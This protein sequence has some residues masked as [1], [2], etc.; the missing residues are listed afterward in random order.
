LPQDISRFLRLYQVC[1]GLQLLESETA[2]RQSLRTLAL[3]A[4]HLQH[5]HYTLLQRK[6]SDTR[7]MAVQG[8]G[9]ATG[10]ERPN[11]E[12][13]QRGAPEL[14]INGKTVQVK[15]DEEDKKK[16]KVGA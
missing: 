7:N 8:S 2:F 1:V 16:L 12:L 10:A 6:T 14:E 13:R 4:F 3:S 9:Y 11:G 15:L 5:D